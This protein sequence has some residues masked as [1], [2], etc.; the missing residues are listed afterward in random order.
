MT[1]FTFVH[2]LISLVAIATGFAV[3]AGLLRS[4]RREVMTTVYLVFTAATNVT[5]FMFLAGNTPAFKLGIISSVVLVACAVARYGFAMRGAWRPTYALSAVT[6]LYFNVFVL[7]V[8][9]FQKIGPLHV[10][11]PKGT[12]LPFAAAQVVVLVGF[13]VTGVI[14]ALRFKPLSS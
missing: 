4:E 2:V 10:L 1:V 13:I 3:T 12:E 8:Q 5:G 6:L 14:A 7:V 11:A 9:A